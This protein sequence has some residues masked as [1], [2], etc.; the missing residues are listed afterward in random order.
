MSGVGPG[1]LVQQF[2]IHPLLGTTTWWYCSRTGQPKVTCDLVLDEV[3][4]NVA[5]CW[6]SPRFSS[7]GSNHPLRPANMWTPTL[8]VYMSPP[9][10][11]K[12][13]SWNWTPGSTGFSLASN[14]YLYW[15]ESTELWGWR[16]E[17]R[18]GEVHCRRSSDLKKFRGDVD[19]TDPR[20]TLPPQ[21]EVVRSWSR[22]I[23]PGVDHPQHASSW[24]G[25]G[26]LC[27]LAGF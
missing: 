27:K 4:K 3:K 21:K 19:H 7:P 6:I 15:S 1:T 22:R 20:P 10:S 18:G 12:T 26:W 17:K 23:T 16:G 9:W 14:Q 2:L 8:K 25:V 11:T 5:R 24:L 13:S